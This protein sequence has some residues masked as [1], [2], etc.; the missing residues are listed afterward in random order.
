[1]WILQAQS[2]ETD[3]RKEIDLS[4][5]PEWIL[6]RSSSADI[7][8]EWDPYLSRQHLHI[9][10]RD[11]TVTVERLDRSKNRVL[12]CGEPVERCTLSSGDEILAGSSLLR[13]VN[14]SAEEQQALFYEEVSFTSDDLQLAP[15]HKAERHLQILSSLPMLVENQS[16]VEALI[17][18]VLDMLAQGITE[19][20]GILI[21]MDDLVTRDGVGSEPPSAERTA[22]VVRHFSRAKLPPPRIS[23]RLW[24]RSLRNAQGA[25][26][27]LWEH[28]LY[29]GGDAPAGELTFDGRYDWA[30]CLPIDL[31]GKSTY[32]IYVYG[33]WLLGDIQQRER[34]DADVRFTNLLVEITSAVLRAQQHDRQRV[35]LEQFL[36]K[37]IARMM[38]EE[39][40]NLLLEPRECELTVLFCDVERFTTR[41]E[42]SN[43]QLLTFLKQISSELECAS[44][45][46]LKFG[47]IIGDFHGDAVM[48]FWGWPLDNDDAP[49]LACQAALEIQENLDR[50][51]E[52]EAE[53]PHGNM[54]IG[55]AS[56]HGIAGKIGTSDQVK[57][58]AFG[59]VV[60]RADRLQ[61]LGKQVSGYVMIDE[62]T[63]SQMGDKPIPEGIRLRPLDEQE[64]PG[65]PGPVKCYC[66]EPD[67]TEDG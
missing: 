21:L 9:V 59:T 25:L 65:I 46:V 18:I 45:A 62:Q 28:A 10:C 35:L 57:L 64:L 8:I 43:E 13:F 16:S 17:E 47:G 56:G 33:H 12:F 7:T 30:F 38:M 63:I 39:P 2:I 23:Q 53:I 31:P 4:G 54:R 40:D 15:D 61:E 44:Q 67:G 49:W 66:L 50:L 48:G 55:I 36:P 14:E 41:A 32:G 52:Q 6:G 3:A 20:D 5:K 58:T 24:R 60:N 51:R 22:C 1:M 34:I 29:G 37:D 19:A 27:H 42:Q 26:L 11:Q